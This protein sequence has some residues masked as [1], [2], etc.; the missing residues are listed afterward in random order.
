MRWTIYVCRAC[1]LKLEIGWSHG[2]PASQNEPLKQYSA[3]TRLICKECGAQY[4]IDMAGKYRMDAYQQLY[5]VILETYESQNKIALMKLLRQQKSFGLN[6]A[7]DVV[8]NLP[9]TLVSGIPKQYTSH[10]KEAFKEINVN[11]KLKKSKKMPIREFGPSLPDRLL[12]RNKPVFL[13]DRSK[14]LSE[15]YNDSNYDTVQ[16]IIDLRGS[17]NIED[18]QE[19]KPDETKNNSYAEILLAKQPCQ[20]CLAVGKISSEIQDG[21]ACP[22]CKDKALKSIA[23]LLPQFCTK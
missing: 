13:E 23:T 19:L 10:W 17:E 18:W 14:I 9:Y 2:V 12:G 16:A 15:N 5:D 3:R 20:I 8:E 7:K 22:H 6:E 21:D 1:G 4:A 11:V